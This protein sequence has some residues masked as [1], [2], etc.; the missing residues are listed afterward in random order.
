MS[1]RLGHSMMGHSS[2]GTTRMW[3]L[4]TCK[5]GHEAGYFAKR[6]SA[7]SAPTPSWKSSLTMH[8]GAVP[9][10]ARHSANSIEKF[11]QGETA[12]G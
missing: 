2:S 7:L 4:L 8:T 11:P 3:W 12:M 10:A 5:A 1:K 9:Q 6:A